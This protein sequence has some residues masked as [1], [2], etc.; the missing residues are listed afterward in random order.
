MVIK[1]FVL[2]LGLVQLLDGSP[3]SSRNILRAD[4]NVRP[5][6]RQNVELPRRP[7]FTGNGSKFYDAMQMQLMSTTII[8]L[9]DEATYYELWLSG[10]LTRTHLEHF[11]RRNNPTFKGL[12]DKQ[13]NMIM[14]EWIFKML[15]GAY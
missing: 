1:L 2:V 3:V 7:R 13:Y 14:E 11:I 10:S 8:S 15:P 6:V 12:S 5:N 9:F 4:S